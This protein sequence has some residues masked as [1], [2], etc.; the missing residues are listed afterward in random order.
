MNLRNILTNRLRSQM[1]RN[2]SLFLVIC[3]FPAFQMRNDE[4]ELLMDKIFTKHPGTYIGIPSDD[5]K[6]KFIVDICAFNKYYLQ[7]LGKGRHSDFGT[8]L[9]QSIQRGIK[10]TQRI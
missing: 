6:R 4:Y 9:K 10:L 8:Y 5:K 1:I 7:H 2:S 3:I